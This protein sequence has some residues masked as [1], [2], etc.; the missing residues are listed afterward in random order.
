MSAVRAD[1]QRA[2][3]DALRAQL[4]WNAATP[5]E[6]RQLA[7]WYRADERYLDTYC[8]DI[9]MS[10]F[11]DLTPI[12]DKG[13]DRFERDPGPA[14][15]DELGRRVKDLDNFVRDHVA[16]LIARLEKGLDL[17]AGL[18]L[19]E[20]GDRKHAEYVA[21]W[22]GV[23]RQVRE[24]LPVSWTIAAPAARLYE[25]LPPA[26]KEEAERTWGPLYQPHPG[27]FGPLWRRHWPVARL[28]A[29]DE[30]AKREGLWP[31]DQE[32]PGARRRPQQARAR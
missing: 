22:I 7:V 12:E 23:R 30:A 6:E 28:V 18:P 9:V 13:R 21:L 32:Y 14:S 11:A 17:M 15:L 10:I 26:L 5:D 19:T 16:P 2:Q 25:S 1:R 31:F 27:N 20:A 4:P 24:A 3:R 8:E 29:V